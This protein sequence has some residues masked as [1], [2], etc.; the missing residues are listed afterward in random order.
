MADFVHVLL[1]QRL[2]RIAELP[3]SSLGTS[4]G[5]LFSTQ[6][7]DFTKFMELEYLLRALQLFQ[8]LWKSL[9]T[10]TVG[11]WPNVDRKHFLISPY[12]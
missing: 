2:Q 6:P 8:I 7:L 5:A 4:S 12:L 11:D 3:L 9:K 10:S 1:S